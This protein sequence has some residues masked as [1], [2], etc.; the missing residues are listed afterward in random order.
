MHVP[1]R[2]MVLQL[3]EGHEAITK[4]ARAVI[5]LVES[6]G[7]AVTLDLLTKRLQVHEKTAWMLRS[8]IVE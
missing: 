4:T 3:L 5:P 7:D 8:L 1:S 2:N 6:A